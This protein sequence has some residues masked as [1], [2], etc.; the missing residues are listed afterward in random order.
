MRPTAKDAEAAVKLLISYAGDDAARRGLERT[1]ARV[2]AAYAEWFGGYN[3]DVPE[4]LATHFGDDDVDA[5]A[6]GRIEDFDGLVLLRGYPF[7]STCEHHLCPFIGVADVGYLPRP[8][9]GTSAGRLVGLSKLGRLVDAY[10]R[11]MQVQERITAQIA[12]ALT[13]ALRPRGVVVRLSAT[14]HCM[15][16][17]GVRA[18][19]AWTDTPMLT[20][21]L[22]DDP[23]AHHEIVTLLGTSSRP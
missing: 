22:R 23:A 14:H 2:V 3:V 9:D 18:H 17:R 6:G 12:S 13:A 15:T 1:P 7:A 21:L 5:L 4:L 11:R 20:G 10:A 8:P 16:T 19:P